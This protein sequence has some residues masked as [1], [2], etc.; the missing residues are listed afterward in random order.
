[1]VASDLPKEITTSWP[2]RCIASVR[3]VR[4]STGNVVRK[5]GGHV[6]RVGWLVANHHRKIRN[7]LKGFLGPPSASRTGKQL[8]EHDQ[9]RPRVAY[10]FVGW[11]CP[12][13]N[14]CTDPCLASKRTRLW[15]TGIGKFLYFLRFLAVPYATFSCSALRHLMKQSPPGSPPATLHAASNHTLSMG[16]MVRYRS[17]NLHIFSVDSSWFTIIMVPAHVE[18][19]GKLTRMH[20]YTLI[21]SYTTTK[22]TSPSFCYKAKSSQKLA[23]PVRN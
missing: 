2:W 11:C 3:S 8:N 15:V 4:Q 21:I 17:S 23:M 10:I 20:L 5:H 12:R 14:S 19:S 22:N 6:Q 18:L 16:L 9:A 13:P 1:V 7:F